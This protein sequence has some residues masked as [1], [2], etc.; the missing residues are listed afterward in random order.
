MGVIARVLEDAGLSTTSITM[1]REH[2]EKVKQPRA[3]FVPFPFGHPYG[4]PFDAE[5]QTRVI[6]AAL[7]LFEAPEGPVLADYTRD[8]GPFAS[9]DLNLPQAAD[10]PGAA[11]EQDPAFEL[12][13]LRPYY[14]QWLAQNGGRTLVGLTGVDQ[15][16]FR[17]LVRLLQSYAAGENADLPQRPANVSVPQV[18]RWASDDLKAFYFEARMAQKPDSSFQ[19][20]HRWFWGETAMGSLLRAVRDRMKAAGDPYLDTMAFGIAR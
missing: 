19:E 3:L 15:R 6:R 20:R 18:I 8:E 7:E 5:G 2:T 1:V 10:L 12:T 4:A 16:R 9:Q 11:I 17:G 14:E 13:S